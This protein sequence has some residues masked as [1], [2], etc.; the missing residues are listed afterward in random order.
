MFSAVRAACVC[1][2][3]A[4]KYGLAEVVLLNHH[5]AVETHAHSP[6]PL[7]ESPPRRLRAHFLRLV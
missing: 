4:V 1:K 6:A 5:A 2:K 3:N 7:Y